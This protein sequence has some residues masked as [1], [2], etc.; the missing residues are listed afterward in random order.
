[1]NVYSASNGSEILSTKQ[2]SFDNTNA[3]L[4]AGKE[5]Q[6]FKY[7]V[8]QTASL[9]E[10]DLN[11]FRKTIDSS[12]AP[13]SLDI[14][15]FYKDK[16]SA[17][18][19]L[20]YLKCTDSM[21]EKAS[22]NCV[23]KN[24]L[25]KNSNQLAM[26]RGIGTVFFIL[27]QINYELHQEFISNVELANDLD[28]TLR[29]LEPYYDTTMDEE[30]P[31]DSEITSNIANMVTQ[32]TSNKYIPSNLYTA[33]V[34]Y[35]TIDYVYSV[36]LEMKN[37]LKKVIEDSI[38]ERRLTYIANIAANITI[39]VF[40]LTIITPFFVVNAVQSN[41]NVSLYANVMINQNKQIKKEKQLTEKLLNEM[42]PMTIAYK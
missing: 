12:N 42:L 20:I 23:N 1:M 26:Q 17:L 7:L 15:F 31:S 38:N 19:E 41:E 24:I 14:Y 11:N 36:K 13:S 5:F 39:I 27:G 32:I 40:I 21:N 33:L 35:R 9:Y 10:Y 18:I 28:F 29:N 22:I 4:M 30:F 3:A 37:Y 2:E 8:P 25:L 6:I 34:W 16:I